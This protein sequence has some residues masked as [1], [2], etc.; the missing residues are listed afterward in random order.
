M[1]K[2]IIREQQ[3]TAVEQFIATGGMIQVLKPKKI[4]KGTTARGKNKSP[5]FACKEY[6]RRQAI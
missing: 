5:T 3:Q 2:H 1:D 4:P 6:A